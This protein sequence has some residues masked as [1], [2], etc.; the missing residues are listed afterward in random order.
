MLNGSA[1]PL[2]DDELTALDTEVVEGRAVSHWG[3]RLQ[4]EQRHR[5]EEATLLS[6]R[7]GVSPSTPVW[8]TP[9]TCH[10]SPGLMRTIA[11]VH[12][13]E[14]RLALVLTRRSELLTWVTVA[15]SRARSVA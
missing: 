10:T 8:T 14:H 6:W 9:M 2:D 5:K 13:D 3:S 1:I 15:A 7:G 4:R 11:A 12:L